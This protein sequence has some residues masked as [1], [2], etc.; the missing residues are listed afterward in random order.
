VID[1][2][3]ILFEVTPRCNLSCRYCYVPWDAPQPR[4]EAPADDHFDQA[5]RTLAVLLKQARVGSVT[6]TGG[7]PML[8]QRLPELA[9]RC[10]L[11]GCAVNIITNG[12]V[13]TAATYAPL[14]KLGVSLFELPL[15]ARNP[16]VH[17]GLAAKPGA[18][19]LVL[20]SVAVLRDLGAEVVGVIV[21]TREN[22]AQVADT[23]A[24]HAEL[25]IG[26]TM[27][28][29]F[30]PGGRGL[31][32][33]RTL[34]PSADELNQAFAA[35]EEV[36]RQLDLRATSNVG[37]PHCLVDPRDFPHLRMTSCSADTNRRP[38]ALDLDGG[39]RFCNHSPVVFANIHRDSPE[40]WLAGDY[41]ASW[42]DTVPAACDQC[43][44][45][46]E[47]FGGCRAASE[48]M[49]GTLAD[50]DPLLSGDLP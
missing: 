50:V 30:N 2:S 14:A 32:N 33:V 41:L 46:P 15:H 38:L 7:E 36:S 34:L 21:L 28:N 24:F 9:L 40:T 45:F 29:R 35:A 17:D 27:L 16:E 48:Q 6:M 39:L 5:D 18:H 22:A 4:L 25:G 10:R 11:A 49:G 47:C 37:L 23:L 8:Q 1:L 19:A 44:R 31:A 26:R 43:H 3:A 20:E 13:G 42:R 12:T